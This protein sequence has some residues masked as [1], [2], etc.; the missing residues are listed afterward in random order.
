V[1]GGQNCV[2]TLNQK[3]EGL[4][5]DV[6]LDGEAILSSVIARNQVP[7]T[8]RPYAGFVGQLLFIDLQGASDP[9]YDGLADR[10]AMVYLSPDDYA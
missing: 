10:F 6:A 8:C 5:I 2:L 4:F 3:T 7:I 1:L 9:S